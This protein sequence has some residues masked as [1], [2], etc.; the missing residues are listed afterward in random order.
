MPRHRVGT[1]PRVEATTLKEIIFPACAA[2]AF[3]GFLPRA[4]RPRQSLRNPTQAALLLIFSL[5]AVAFAVS[6]PSVSAGLDRLIGVHNLSALLIDCSLVICSCV[7]QVLVLLWA[8]PAAR[9]VPAIRARLILYSL[10]LATMITLFLAAGS[11]D[12]IR[13]EDF[14]LHYADNPLIAAYLALFLATMSAGMAVMLRLCLRY[15]QRA[16]S[17]WL[18]RGLRI[19]AAGSASGL[20]YCT[21][22]VGTGISPLLGWPRGIWEMGVAVFGGGAAVLMITGLT[23]PSWGPS[24]GAARRRLGR[25]RAY[26]RLHPLWAA[27][28]RAVPEIVLPRPDASPRTR[29]AFKDLDFRLRRKIIEIRDG[30]RALQPWRDRGDAERAEKSGREAGLS[31]DALAASVEAAALESAIRAKAQGE[32]G[33]SPV[34]QAAQVHGGKDLSAELAWLEKVARAFAQL[35][36]GDLCQA[37]RRCPAGLPVA[38]ACASCNPRHRFRETLRTAVGGP[39]VDAA[40]GAGRRAPE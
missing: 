24:L 16:G 14:F 36:Y 13:A 10:V 38:A 3:L 1:L 27:I 8:Y 29:F 7:I 20:G 26:Y 21:C 15:S 2:L 18:R 35:Q 30:Q 17:T 23:I 31:G 4:V 32:P 11:T 25:Y 9:A 5:A 22:R 39:G 12:G 28:T 33:V 34:S 19:T 37:R 40:S 6:T